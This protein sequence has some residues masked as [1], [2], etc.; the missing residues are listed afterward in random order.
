LDRK[1]LFDPLSKMARVF[2]FLVLYFE[3]GCA[4]FKISKTRQECCA[5]L[6]HT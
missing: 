2:S 6:G 5:D 4:L 3:L 1:A